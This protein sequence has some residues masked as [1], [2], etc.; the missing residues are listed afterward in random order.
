[1]EPVFDQLYRLYQKYIDEERDEEREEQDIPFW[2]GERS[3]VGFLAAAVWCSGGNALEEYGKKKDRPRKGRCD[4]FIKFRGK[5]FEC[6]A[7]FVRAQ[8]KVS[9]MLKSA[10]DNARESI[11]SGQT[12]LALL[13][14]GPCFPKLEDR[15]YQRYIRRWKSKLQRLRWDALVWIGAKPGQALQL[16]GDKRYCYPGMFLLVR[17]VRKP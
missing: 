13:F 4:L 8:S 14:W 7:K 2:Y 9:Q 5:S 11:E 6:E 12:G 15:N 1:M 10:S 17:Q 3:Q 16:A